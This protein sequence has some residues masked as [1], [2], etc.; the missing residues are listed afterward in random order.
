MRQTV[1]AAI[2][3]GTALMGGAREA[4]AQSAYDYRYCAIY[5]NKSGATA[6]YY[7]NYEQCMATMRGIGG[8]CIESP[9]Y[10]GPKPVPRERP[11][12]RRGED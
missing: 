3:I 6:C 7:S 10:T 11:R 1:F 9:Y 5:T 8:Y 2:L 4:A 12:R